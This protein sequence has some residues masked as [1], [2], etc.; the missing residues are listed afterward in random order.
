MPEIAPDPRVAGRARWNGLLLLAASFLSVTGGAVTTVALTFGLLELKGQADAVGMVLA[1]RAVPL[2]LFLLLGG[3]IADRID[4]RLL[5]IAADGLRATAQLLLGYLMLFGG[6][7]IPVM[8]SL[9][10]IVG[11]GD[12]LFVPSQSGLVPELLPQCQLQQL[13]ARMGLVSSVA[14]I[15]GPVIGGILVKLAGSGLAIAVDGLTFVLSA[16]ILAQIRRPAAAH[17]SQSIGRDA[18]WTD[19]KLGFQEFLR[20][21]W[22][23][24]MVGQAALFHLLVLGPLFILGPLM[25][26]GAADGAL[27]WSELL[28]AWAAGG[29]CGGVAALNMKPRYP[30]AY[31]AALFPLSA[32]IPAS[33]ALPLPHVVR[34]SAFGFGSACLAVFA[35]FWTTTLHTKIPSDV[36]SRVSAFDAVV[37][38]SLLP[39]GYVLAPALL[40]AVGINDSFWIGSAVCLACGGVLLSRDVR[41][42]QS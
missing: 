5:M 7:T 16:L 40:A 2:I 15:A 8:M 23:T 3:V 18:I 38:L 10:F 42:L 11:M 12:A 17:Q 35:V 19:L 20:R 27:R 25:F 32:V 41:A 33:L 34:L 21:R 6:A 14:G 24:L 9:A 22:L 37:S 30:L 31:A 13:N 26:K 1:S 36:I 28:S 39:A 4:R 29:L